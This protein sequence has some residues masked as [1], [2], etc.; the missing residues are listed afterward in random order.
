MTIYLYKHMVNEHF[1]IPLINKLGIKDVHC[2]NIC[3]W[4]IWWKAEPVYQ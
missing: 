1:N 2:L 4:G 3:D